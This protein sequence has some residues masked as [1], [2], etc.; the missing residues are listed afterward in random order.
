MRTLASLGMGEG[1]LCSVLCCGVVVRCWRWGCAGGN[2]SIAF[3]FGERMLKVEGEGE[4][5]LVIAGG[6]VVGEEG[7]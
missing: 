2:E 7:K 3:F 5:I 1:Q 6:F 4:S